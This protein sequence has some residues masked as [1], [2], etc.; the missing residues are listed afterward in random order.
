MGGSYDC[1]KERIENF[2]NKY[3]SNDCKIFICSH[4][5]TLKMLRLLILKKRATYEEWKRYS[6]KNGK[7]VKIRCQNDIAIVISFSWRYAFKV[8]G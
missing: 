1:F 6:F 3:I 2:Y 8:M 4:N 5:Q 7:L